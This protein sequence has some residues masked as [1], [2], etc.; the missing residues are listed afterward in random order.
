MKIKLNYLKLSMFL[1]MI[2]ILFN[3]NSSIFALQGG[4]SNSFSTTAPDYKFYHILNFTG[5]LVNTGETSV[6]PNDENGL[7]VVEADAASGGTTNFTIAQNRMWFKT[8]NSDASGAA[9]LSLVLNEER[10]NNTMEWHFNFSGTLSDADSSMHNFYGDNASATGTGGA[11]VEAFLMAVGQGTAGTGGIQVRDGSFAAITSIERDTA[12]VLGDNYSMKITVMAKNTTA[13]S[14]NMSVYRVINASGN[15]NYI[16]NGSM[17]EHTCGTSATWIR[18]TFWRISGDS[19][20][21]IGSFYTGIDEIVMWNG[22]GARPEVTSADTTPPTVNITYRNITTDVKFNDILNITCFSTGSPTVGNITFNDTGKN[23]YNFSYVLTGTEALFSQNR[24]LNATKGT[25]IN[26]TCYAEDSSGNRHHNSTLFRVDDTVGS[27]LINS[28]NSAIRRGEIINITANSSDVD[29]DFSIGMISYNISGKATINFTYSLDSVTRAN[30]SQNFTTNA[31]RGAII[32]F[33]AYHNDT[34]G[35]IIQNSTLITVA[36]TLGSILIS[37]NNTQPRIND[38]INISGNVT[39]IDGD[40]E[41][42]MIANNRSGKAT[43]NTT[44]SLTAIQKANFSTPLPIN[45]SGG[46]KINLTVFYNDTAGTIIQ[47]STI[48]TVLNTTPSRPS[49]VNASAKTVNQNKSINWTSS[50]A[51][52]DPITFTICFNGACTTTT[53]YNFTTNMVNHGDYYLNI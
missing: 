45:V 12:M 11:V 14:Y 6:I 21:P 47:N 24:T 1:I 28:N 38:V 31:S 4:S 27:I 43:F 29:R 39:D 37:V 46:T 9:T 26:A 42:G 13:C 36:D 51:D 49:I 53:D 30:I 33:T 10:V 8:D 17:N 2:I 19:N 5:G 25:W 23:L 18:K 44:F 16:E 7:S 52:G 22:T 41:T 40:S 50:D 20:R 15:L 3:L 34:N 35:T 48:I 32:N